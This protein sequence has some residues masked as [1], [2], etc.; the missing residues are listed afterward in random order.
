MLPFNTAPYVQQ[1]RSWPS[2]GRHIMATFDDHSIIVYQAYND[3]I[4]DAALKANN[5][6]SDEVLR[7]GYNPNRMSWIKTNFLWMMYRSG[8][9][10]KPNQTRILAIRITRQGFE[11]IL[12]NASRKGPSPV[13]LQWDPDHDPNGEKIP[14]RRAIQLGLRGDML[15][16]FS[17]EHLLTITDITAFVREQAENVAETYD[18]LVVPVENVYHCLNSLAANSVC[19]DTL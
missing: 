3:A 15:E 14:D 16:R 5:F 18:S 2:A 11:D 12:L 13:R 8:W 4:A 1:A 9:A 17:R 10:M 7:A 19:I 6:H